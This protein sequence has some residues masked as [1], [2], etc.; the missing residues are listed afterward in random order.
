[1]KFKKELK[2]LFDKVLEITTVNKGKINT[3]NCTRNF[4][5]INLLYK[6][7]NINRCVNKNGEFTVFDVDNLSFKNIRTDYIC[8]VKNLRVY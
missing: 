1:M 7:K 4:N 6:N 8:S 3:I 5:I 2:S